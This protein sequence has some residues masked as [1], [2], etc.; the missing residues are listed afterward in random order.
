MH[1]RTFIE[2]GA[3]GGAA[4]ATGC[5][6]LRSQWRVL[7]DAEARTLAA[8]CDQIIPPDDFPGAAEAGAVEFIDRQLSTHY[9]EHRD[10]YR[11]GLADAE[12]YSDA[13]FKRPV[14]ALS[15]DQ[16]TQIAKALEKDRPRFFRLLLAHTMQGFY[17]SPRH[18]GNHD[19]VSWRMLGLPEPQVRGR[20]QFDLR[21]RGNS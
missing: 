19:A 6:T 10:A 21:K 9:R 13:Q 20:A 16:Q 17:G 5:T 11:R 14:A 2:A 15:F 4:A 8:L 3:I 1:R 12:A 18:G 7:T